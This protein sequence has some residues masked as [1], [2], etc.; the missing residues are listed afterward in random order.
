M[1]Q[2]NKFEFTFEVTDVDLD[3]EQRKRVARAVTLAGVEAL[4]DALPREF[5]T[6]LLDS[7][8]RF[9]RHWCGIPPLIKR[10]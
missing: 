3:D 10:D 4:G 1:P 9:I 5:S 2:D 7:D 6:R 8:E